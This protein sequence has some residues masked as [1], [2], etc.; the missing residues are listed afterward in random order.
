MRVFN[1]SAGPAMLPT[2]VLEQAQSELLDWQGSG[3]SVMEV[4]HRSKPFVACADQT[5]ALLREVLGVPENY[6]V[7]FLQGGASAQ[8]DAIPLNLT[9]PGDRVDFLNTGQWS[10]KAI[11]AAKRQGLEV[12]VLADEAASKYTTVPAAGSYQVAPSAAY[13]HYTPTR[14]SVGSSSITSRKPGT[15]RWWR[16][17]RPPSCRGRWTSRATG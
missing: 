3:M 15:S 11:K 1:F 16:I 17:S 13:L 2:S 7:L 5:E 10:A 12:T 4:S 9:N 6:K 14:R 8:F